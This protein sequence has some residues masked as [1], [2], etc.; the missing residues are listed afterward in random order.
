M[1]IGIFLS[2]K[3]DFQKLIKIRFFPGALFLFQ[4]ALCRQEHNSGDRWR[5]EILLLDVHPLYTR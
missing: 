1:R 3:F 5:N 4:K 2:Y